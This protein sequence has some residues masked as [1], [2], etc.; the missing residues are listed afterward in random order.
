MNGF[1]L[2]WSQGLISLGLGEWSSAEEAFTQAK[3][4]FEETG[5]GLHAAITSLELA[6]VWMHQGRC[7]ETAPMVSEAVEVFVALGIQREALGAVLV[8]REAFERGVATLGLLEKVVEFLRRWQI[9][10]NARFDLKG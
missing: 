8:L 5:M 4:G 3:L 9:D 6:V 10:P 1:K 7:A 2:L